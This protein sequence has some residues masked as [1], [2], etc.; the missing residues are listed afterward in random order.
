MR[1]RLVILIMLL[2]S[3]QG[4]FDW[5]DH[6]YQ[7]GQE[8]L[9][10]GSDYDVFFYNKEL[11]YSSAK[12]RNQANVNLKGIRQDEFHDTHLN[13]GDDKALNLYKRASESFIE[14]YDLV[15]SIDDHVIYLKKL[16]KVIDPSGKGFNVILRVIQEPS[17]VLLDDG[18]GDE[19]G[20]D[21][22][23]AED[24]DDGFG[25]EVSYVA[26][27][28]LKL[29]YVSFLDVIESIC[30]KNDFKYKITDHA[31]IIA[32]RSAGCGCCSIE[33][34]SMPNGSKYSIEFLSYL[35]EMVDW[36]AGAQLSYIQSVN[37][38]VVKNSES[39]LNYIRRF[40]LPNFEEVM[41]L[42]FYDI[43][44][45]AL[46]PKTRVELEKNPQ[47]YELREQEKIAVINQRPRLWRDFKF[48]Y[49]V[50]NQSQLMKIEYQGKV[51]EYEYL[52]A[53]DQ[54]MPLDDNQVLLLKIR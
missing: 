39:N 11:M 26:P 23:F 28:S 10:Q 44:N 36:D 3:C 25:D 29:K 30:L 8:A 34:F 53:C 47:R 5:E 49:G 45:D 1:V 9:L 13:T 50:R 18:F 21:D 32:D 12:Y 27:I 40:V 14:E 4:S 43:K 22:P 24:L 42:G 7:Q 52:G 46:P 16:S 2:C 20:A 37:R 54:L 41:Q 33:F 19:L 48:S 31:I 38:L 17:R 35:R 6:F 51:Y 15:G